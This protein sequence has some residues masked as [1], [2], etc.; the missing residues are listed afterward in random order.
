MKLNENIYG[1]FGGDDDDGPVFKKKKN[2]KMSDREKKLLKTLYDYYSEEETFEKGDDVKY[3]KPG[4]DYYGKIGKFLGK[5]ESDGKIQIKYGRIVFN[6]TSEYVKKVNEDP[7]KLPK[8]FDR[9]IKILK[10]MVADGD[11]SQTSMDKFLKELNVEQERKEIDP[12]QEENWEE[13]ESEIIKPKPPPIKRA[14]SY[15]PCSSG[16]GSSR[17]C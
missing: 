2:D 10:Q 11:L 9:L 17:G 14:P 3:N 8:N 5:R 13:E 12:Y 15:D 1:A 7:K 16:G 4:S 6:A